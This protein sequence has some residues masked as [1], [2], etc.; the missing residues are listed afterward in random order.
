MAHQWNS[1]ECTRAHSLGT[2]SS[3]EHFQA[4]LP[5]ENRRRRPAPFMP[6]RSCRLGTSLPTSEALQ[7][8]AHPAAPAV[9]RATHPVLPTAFNRRQ[10][11]AGEGYSSGKNL[12]AA[13][14]CNT[15]RM[16]PDRP[17]SMPRNGPGCPCAASAMA[18]ADRSTPTAR[19]STTQIASCSCK[20]FKPTASDKRISLDA[21]PIYETRSSVLSLK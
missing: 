15:H 12:R 5:V 1:V 2:P 3:Q 21:E 8:R 6:E 16:P 14:I 10:Q 7:H 18:A 11:V 19:P 13:P 17:G 20:K 9:R 4:E